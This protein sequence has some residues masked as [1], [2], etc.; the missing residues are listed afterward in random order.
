VSRR[1]LIAGAGIGGLTAAIALADKGFDVTIFERAPALAPIGTGV[2][3]TPNATRILAALDALEAARSQSLAP[4]AIRIRR[5]SDGRDLSRLSLEGAERRWRAP[6]LVMLRAALQQALLERLVQ[7][8]NARLVLGAEVSGVQQ[9]AAGA[10]I[11]LHI[12]DQTISERGDFL[13]GADGVNSVVRESLGL[14]S[15]D[16]AR[17]SGR[18]AFRATIEA[19]ALASHMLAPDVVLHLGPR[20]HLVHY[21]VAPGG[22]VNVVAAFEARWRDAPGDAPWDG[23]ADRA[24]LRRAYADWAPETRSFLDAVDSWRAWPLLER[25]VA[26]RVAIGRVA[27]LGDAAHAMA[28]FLAQGAAQAIEDAAALSESLVESNDVAAALATYARRR[29][30]RV[31]RIHREA[32]EQARLYHMAGPLALARDIGMRAMGPERLLRR[33]DWIYG[34]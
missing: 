8:P 32:R 20:A 17:F 7:L 18:V 9:D 4:R 14:G 21:P 3:L 12:N 28:P 24:A 5:G 13:V 1:A 2:Q 23:T 27:L 26:A 22:P 31:A 10:I 34:A 25:P 15:R 11:A 30:P 19:A 6:Y 33:Y 16:G 29:R